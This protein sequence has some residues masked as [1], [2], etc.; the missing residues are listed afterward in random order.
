[1]NVAE[2]AES[3]LLLA[4]RDKLRDG[5]GWTEKQC[6][7]EQ[8]E[9]APATVGQLYVV[10]LPGG[11]SNGPRHNTSGGVNDLLFSVDVAVIKRAASTP[12]DRRR[13]LFLTNLDGLN[14]EVGKVFKWVDFRYD[15]LDAANE[16]IERETGIEKAFVE[17]LKFSTVDRRPRVVGGE[18]FAAAANQPA[19]GLIRVV[20]FVGARCVTAKA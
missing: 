7:V 20:S 2:I 8:D 19:A 4:V 12:R 3:A 18:M 5:E 1:M 16:L 14:A 9:I 6:E 13:N 15:V 10:V 11:W 17:P